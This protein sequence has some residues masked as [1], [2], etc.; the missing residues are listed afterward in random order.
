[1]SFTFHKLPIMSALQAAVAHGSVPLVRSNCYVDQGLTIQRCSHTTAFY[2]AW[3]YQK[4][5]RSLAH[6]LDTKEA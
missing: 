1:V 6:E 2:T 5:L 4:A 3:S